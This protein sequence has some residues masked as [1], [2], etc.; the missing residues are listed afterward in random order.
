[1]VQPRLIAASSEPARIEVHN[2][3]GQHTLSITAAGP[4][5]DQPDMRRTP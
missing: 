3:D 4:L 5:A 2:E 1:M